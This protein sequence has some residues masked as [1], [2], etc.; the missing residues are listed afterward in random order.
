MNEKGI[1]RLH[2]DGVLGSFDLESYQTCESCLRGKMIK[3]PFNRKC[4][5]ESGL[6]GLIHTDVCGPLSTSARGGYSY[7]VAFT[8]DLSRYAMS[9]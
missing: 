7:F 3:S 4:E 5:R 6:F 8:D 1:S 9:I 2:K